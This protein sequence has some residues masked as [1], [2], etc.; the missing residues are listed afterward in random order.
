[1]GFPSNPSANYDTFSL[2]FNLP[3]QPL[4][5]SKLANANMVGAG[6]DQR[7][8]DHGERKLTSVNANL[9]I[10][11]LAT[12]DHASKALDKIGKK[13]DKL[14]NK[15]LDFAVNQTSNVLFKFGQLGIELPSQDEILQR[16]AIIE[17]SH[18]NPFHQA[19][20]QPIQQT[21]SQ[22]DVGG[23][24]IGSEGCPLTCTPHTLPEAFRQPML[25]VVQ[26]P[27]TLEYSCA[28]ILCPLPTAF[29]ISEGVVK[30]YHVAFTMTHW[31]QSEL[32]CRLM[33]DCG[34]TEEELR[35]YLHLITDLVLYSG[36]P[37]LQQHKLCE[38]WLHFIGLSAKPSSN[39]NTTPIQQDYS[40]G[41][42]YRN[43]S[44]NICYEF[45][46]VQPPAN[47]A[48]CK[49]GGA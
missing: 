13:L 27:Q 12:Q 3:S 6:L 17:S 34:W 33:R 39:L 15:N 30:P 19:A 37:G 4:D 14:D 21:T 23:G 35:P 10:L 2:G 7:L 44:N 28:S 49:P 32:F 5:T 42:W 43:P 8:L 25:L 9:N 36:Q 16:K 47:W 24:G 26:S 29:V 20:T 11:D 18:H 1:M 46:E 45:I 40:S 38:G 48:H 31:Y 41:N 22:L